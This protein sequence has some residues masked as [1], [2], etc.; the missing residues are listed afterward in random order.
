MPT[1]VTMP[2]L[3]E[4]IVEGKIVRW[5]KVVGD[6]VD[7]D[8]PLFEVSTDKVDAEIPSPVRGVVTEV[9]VEVGETVEVDSIVA[10]I[11]TEDEQR[12]TDSGTSEPSSSLSTTSIEPTEKVSSREPRTGVF[13]PLVRKLAEERGIDLGTVTGTGRGGRVTKTDVLHHAEVR[14]QLMTGSHLPGSRAEPLSRMRQSIAEHMVFSRRTSAHAHTV[15]D[16][17]FTAMDIFRRK[18]RDNYAK[19]GVKLTYLS[20]IARAVV[21]AIEAVP[22]INAQLANN[23]TEIIYPRS[24]NLG[25]AVSV[26]EGA[27]EDDGGGLIV[28]VVKDASNKNILELSRSIEDLATRAR[29]K[30]LVPDDVQHGTFTITNP[31]VFGS[32]FGLPIIHQPQ[33]AILCVG[34]IEKRPVVV[35]E[36]GAIEARVRSYLT[37]GFDHRLIDGAIADRFMAKVKS[38]LEQFDGKSL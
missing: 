20:F 5:N 34:A 15:F 36:D 30:R 6:R 25:I 33:V 27:V 23:G 35:N 12:A 13:S 8:E 19:E 1:N 3:G 7:R 16:V 22:I 32:I 18:Y 21:L 4:S 10:V 28:P 9:R 17:D 26:E 31:G 37:L 14:A 2:Q 29:D 11:A 38:N 24:V